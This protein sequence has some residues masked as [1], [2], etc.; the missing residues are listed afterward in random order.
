MDDSTQ[1][2]SA[3]AVGGCGHNTHIDEYVT[4]RSLYGGPED[5]ADMGA[6]AAS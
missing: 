4:R 3:G 1:G 2:L 6:A 5:G